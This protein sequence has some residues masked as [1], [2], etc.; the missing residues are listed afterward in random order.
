MDNFLKSIGERIAHRMDIV[1]I[2]A[3]ELSRRVGRSQSTVSNWRNDIGEPSLSDSVKVCQILGCSLQWLATGHEG[4]KNAYQIFDHNLENANL[5]LVT[6]DGVGHLDY[7]SAPVNRDYRNLVSEL[8]VHR[9]RTK[10]MEPL[11]PQGAN[12]LCQ[13]RSWKQVTDNAII[14]WR[15]SADNW[16]C[17]TV[18]REDN[19][20]YMID[21]ENE[22]FSANRTTPK[23]HHTCY[24]VLEYTVESK[25]LG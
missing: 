9:L 24:E 11:I 12:L 1:D 19:G 16:R 18:Y 4:N 23:D 15:F 17:G 7:P 10:E 6:V 5:S 22:K 8:R 3:S 13:L 21:Y 25:D 20:V 2:N 14:V